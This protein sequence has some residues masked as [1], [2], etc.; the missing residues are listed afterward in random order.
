M[1]LKKDRIYKQSSKDN[2]QAQPQQGFTITLVQ[3][4]EQREHHFET[5]WSQKRVSLYV[6]LEYVQAGR[7][8]QVDAKCGLSNQRG[9]QKWGSGDGG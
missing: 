5:T 3:F 4:I 9:L 6:K 8:G 2:I 7:N 1:I